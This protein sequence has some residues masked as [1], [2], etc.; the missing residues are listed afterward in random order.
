MAVYSLSI[1]AVGR[2]Q[3]VEVDA[4]PAFAEVLGFR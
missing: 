4:P 2:R 1:G 3:T